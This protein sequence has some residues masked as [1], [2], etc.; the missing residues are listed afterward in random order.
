M[1]GLLNSVYS[2]FMEHHIS[3]TELARRLGDIL[4]R[5]RYLRDSF[6]IE[7]NGDPIA[8]LT[9]IPGESVATVREGLTAWAESGEPDAAFADALKRVSTEDRVPKDPWDS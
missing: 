4:G 7:R 1:H 6:V 2:K 8:L 3:S 5:I 9:P